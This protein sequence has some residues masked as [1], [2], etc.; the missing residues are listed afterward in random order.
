MLEYLAVK[1]LRDIY[2]AARFLG[3]RLAKRAAKDALK[4]HSKA[5]EEIYA[6]YPELKGRK[7]V[8]VNIQTGVISEN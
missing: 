4:A 1:K 7:N 2:V 6:V 3:Y 5:W 8:S